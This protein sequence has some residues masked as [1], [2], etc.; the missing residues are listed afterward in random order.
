M[1][2]ISF[3]LLF[4]SA[5][6]EVPKNYVNNDTNSYI[7]DLLTYPIIE[8]KSS[9]FVNIAESSIYYKQAIGSF[10]NAPFLLDYPKSGKTNLAY[11]FLALKLSSDYYPYLPVSIRK[12]LQNKA[13]LPIDVDL[14][15]IAQSLSLLGEKE[16]H[17]G[18]DSSYHTTRICTHSWLDQNIPVN[19]SG[20]RLLTRADIA[21]F[22]SQYNISDEVK[23]NNFENFEVNIHDSVLSPRTAGIKIDT[24]KSQYFYSVAIHNNKAAVTFHL[25][26]NQEDESNWWDLFSAKTP[27]NL[28]ELLLIVKN[29]SFKDTNYFKS[30]FKLL[31]LIN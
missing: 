25:L 24:S 22:D 31:N 29:S 27:A 28:Q 21:I 23:N 17:Q 12:A 6:C 4:L 8:T 16:D 1:I 15:I 30:M 7:K 10:P 9:Y 18:Q 19:F 5:C 2:Y 11:P 26:L 3:I 20:Q 13:I 14:F